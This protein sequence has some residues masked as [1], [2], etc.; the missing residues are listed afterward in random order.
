[1]ASV[2]N[3]AMREIGRFSGSED[4]ER[5]INRFEMAVRID[6]L[7]TGEADAL[8]LKLDGAAY[9]TWNGLSQTEQ[10]DASKIKQALRRA[11]GKDRIEAWTDLLSGALIPGEALDAC[12]ERIKKDVAI[13]LADSDPQ[14]SAGALVLLGRLDPDVRDKVVLHL[15]DNLS[16]AGVVNAAKKVS[17]MTTSKLAS[18]AGYKNQGDE[19]SD[20]VAAIAKD[21]HV[22][23]SPGLLKSR[24]RCFGCGQLGHVRRECQAVCYVCGKKGHIRKNC[25]M[26]GSFKRLRGGTGHA[27]C[28]QSVRMVT[29]DVQIEGREGKALVDTGSTLSL[30]SRHIASK[31]K[32]LG[33]P[34]KLE[35]MDGSCAWTEGR[36]E[37]ENVVLQNNRVSRMSAHVLPMAPAGVDIVLGLDIVLQLGMSICVQDG[38]T[39]VR[40]GI[41]EGSHAPLSCA[42]PKVANI[43]DDDFSAWFSGQSWTVRWEW[44]GGREKLSPHAPTYAIRPSARAGF[45]AEVEE[46][47]KEGILIPWDEKVH[48]HIRNMVPLMAVEQKKGEHRKV[49]PVLDFRR[50]NDSLKSSPGAATPLCQDR[51]REWRAEGLSCALVDLQKAYL[52]VWMDKELWVYQAVQWNNK[53][54][55]L[56]RLGFGLNIAPK[57]M[58][59]I[60]EWV[61]NQD[62]AV[63]KGTSSYI[64]DI[65]VNETVVSAELVVKHL[66]SFGLRAK[67]PEWISKTEGTRMLGVRVQSN[68]EW[69]RDAPLPEVGDSRVT[70]RRVH[71]LVGVARPFACCRMVEA[72]L[73]VPSKM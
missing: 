59:A 62:E 2:Q 11:Y 28:P 27:C 8:A 20:A 71:S 4:V 37:F 1:M 35:L 56:T 36:V 19:E 18:A 73:R 70:R 3:N 43:A 67:P 24:V 12:A 21:R 55:L 40:L 68:G 69:R 5:W 38:S 72:S 34:L 48:G 33:P 29:V 22:K 61:L 44:K 41:S 51:M 50:L 64:D 49:R 25:Q 52:Q 23:R 54:Y 17:R 42:V 60:V 31:C 46:W 10:G 14:D 53:V 63:K 6:G 66:S 16:V 39:M 65:L 15:G 58:T 26:D 32:R 57:V 13:A 47:V 7:Q 45:D 30:V 9:D